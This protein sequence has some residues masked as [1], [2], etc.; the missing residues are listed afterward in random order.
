[1][2]A[3][4]YRGISG[5][6]AGAAVL[7][8]AALCM[9]A[10][11]FDVSRGSFGGGG[12]Y[13]VLAFDEPPG[14][15]LDDR[16]IGER[17]RAAGIEGFISESTQYVLL[18]DFGGLKRI[19]LDRYDVE[20][21]ESFDPRNDGYA[22]RLRSVFVRDGK[23]RFFIA[24]DGGWGP[25]GL[26]RRLDRALDIPYRLDRL[27]GA[28]SLR[29]RL[30]LG[31]FALAGTLL[32]VAGG[33]GLDRRLFRRGRRPR[34][35][36]L[37]LLALLPCLGA[38]APSGSGGFALGGVL[39]AFHSCFLPPLRE[40][41]ARLAP[42]GPVTG[43]NAAGSALS[44]RLPGLHRG[45]WGAL[46]RRGLYRGH[47]VAAALLFALAVFLVTFVSPLPGLLALA[48]S[49]A[50][51]ALL[52][53]AGAR[54]ASPG[55]RARFIPLPIL[56]PA[57]PPPR[58]LI[59]WALAALAALLIPGLGPAGAS[60][61]TGD[62]P[63]PEAWER[64]AAFQSSF[65]TTPLDRSGEAPPYLNYA[66]DREGLI[67]AAGAPEETVAAGEGPALLELA[68]FLEGQPVSRRGGAAPALILLAL[69]LPGLFARRSPP[70]KGRGLPGYGLKRNKQFAA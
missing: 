33:R 4:I 5:V 47:C 6:A 28:P 17:L 67:R 60:F 69:S 30:L 29:G 2:R 7:L 1:V 57:G 42:E 21:A 8:L 14:G 10:A 31:A 24:L 22:E 54:R 46:K 20:G 25:G 35:E 16:G 15:G 3:F 51:P 40:F 59:P 61:D 38:L 63:G 48:S 56:A 44:G 26:E 39:L 37:A 52:L 36:T 64:H 58:T 13:A 12:G 55:G 41:F 19:A 34:V 32:C 49:L 66:L 70:G 23:R 62:I 65:S 53:R 27:G 68:A 43:G 11:F 50:V 45:L 18:D 9:A